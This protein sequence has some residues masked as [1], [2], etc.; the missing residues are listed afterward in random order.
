MKNYLKIISV[1]CLLIFV[2]LTFMACEL[3][4]SDRFYEQTNTV[5]SEFI[6]EICLNEE[7]KYSEGIKY[8]AR[9]ND[10]LEKIENH[11]YTDEKVVAYTELKDVYDNIFT[12]SF[13]FLS[14]FE[15]IFLVVPAKTTSEMKNDYQKFEKLVKDVKETIK[16][17]HT[18]VEQL[19]TNIINDSQANAVG[20]ISLQHLREY[21]RKLI[22]LCEKV[23][24]LDNNFLELCQKYI[25]PKFDTFKNADGSYIE[26]TDVQ[27]K[28]Q[29]TI[30]NLQSVIE[31]I[32]P[33]IKYL[34]SFNGDYVKLDT[35]NIFE[36]LNNYVQL[37]NT[38]TTVT[39]TV[40]ELQDY[41]D[42]YNSYMN[43]KECF[44]RSLDSVDMAV[45]RIDYHFDLDEYA[46]EDANRFTYIQKIYSFTKNSVVALY[47][48]NQ[49]LC[50][51]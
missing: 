6:T 37:D 32:T 42:V 44:Y 8:G 47:K 36:T 5:Y 46:K 1:F 43:D 18:T 22:N 35:D 31:T 34:N 29:K 26:L 15:G 19:D 25:Y 7:T 16:G 12:A 14:A 13:H 39:A 24:E 49:K 33:A 51:E 9:V 40:Q 11:T 21:K 4:S 41:L 28:N 2:S 38:N 23:V 30:S 27:L 20:S 48:V 50:E 3:D 45:F 10:V 17:F